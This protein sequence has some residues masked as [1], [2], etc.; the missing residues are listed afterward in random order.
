MLCPGLINYLYLLLT[1][2]HLQGS[3]ILLKLF[4]ESPEFSH[5]ATLFL[6]Y[7]F[8]VHPLTKPIHINYLRLYKIEQFASVRVCTKMTIFSKNFWLST[9]R[10]IIWFDNIIVHCSFF[11]SLHIPLVTLTYVIWTSTPLCRLLVLAVHVHMQLCICS[12]TKI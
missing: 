10:I 8:G 11:H 5:L 6:S 2:V 7:Q 9:I 12:A 1:Q 4:I 3:L